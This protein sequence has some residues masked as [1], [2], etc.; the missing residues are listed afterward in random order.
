VKLRIQ[1]NSVRLR[2]RRSEVEDFARN[3]KVEA[4]T[5]FSPASI[6]RYSLE[7]ADVAAP[8]VTFENSSVRVL[9]P[10]KLAAAWTSGEDVGITGEFAGISI[11][12]ERDFQRTFV[13][14]KIDN[15]LYPN[16]RSRT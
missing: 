2:L 5:V 12:V 15:D 7:A 9:V 8:Q 14:S 4:Q 16:P 3:G 11:L 10:G 1:D 13:K 6:L